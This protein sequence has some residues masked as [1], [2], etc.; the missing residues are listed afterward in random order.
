MQ[1]WKLR[2]LSIDGAFF[3]CSEKKEGFGFVVG[4][5]KVFGSDSIGKREI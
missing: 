5:K 3:F 4:F 1:A 2:T